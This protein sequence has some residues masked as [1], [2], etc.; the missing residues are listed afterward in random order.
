MFER[1]KQAALTAGKWIAS[2]QPG[3]VAHKGPVDLV[4]EV[5]LG[6]EARIRDALSESGVPVF[7]EEGGGAENAKTRWIVDPLDGTTNFVHGFPSYGVSIALQVD[8]VLEIGV[9][10]DIPRDRLYAASRG[11]GASCNGRTIQ[12]SKVDR[13]SHSLVASGFAVDR[14]EKADDYLRFVKVMLERSQGFR[15][16]G[17]ASLDLCHVACG[18]LDGFW[19]FNLSPWDVAAGCLILSEA[20]GRFTDIDGGPMQ[21]DSPRVLASN[22]LIHQEM[23]QALAPLLPLISD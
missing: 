4:T 17:A 22:G 14:R 11:H 2:Q 7:A 12:V 5:D 6:A 15:R 19:E 21:V 13:L 3:V 10:Y 16:A 23:H 9:V 8:G 18:Q 1:A 20:G